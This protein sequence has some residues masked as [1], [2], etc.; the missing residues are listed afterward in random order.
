M[1]V[2]WLLHDQQVNRQTVYGSDLASSR[3]RCAYAL[4]GLEALGVDVDVAHMGAQD[5]NLAAYDVAVVG[6][7]FSEK[8]PLSV[9]RIS[10]YVP[11][12]LDC[13]DISYSVN[14]GAFIKASDYAAAVVVGSDFLRQ[15][16]YRKEDIS[17]TVITDCCRTEVTPYTSTTSTNLFWCGYR[18]NSELLDRSGYAKPHVRTVSNGRVINTD[19]RPFSLENLYE[20]FRWADVLLLPVGTNDYYQAKG[21]GRLL[22]AIAHGV[23]PVA[24]PHPAWNG[25]DGL[26]TFETLQE[27]VRWF[28]TNRD[29]EVAESLRIQ[30]AALEGLHSPLPIAREW[31]SVF[32]R[33]RE[34]VSA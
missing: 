10:A 31:M 1:R 8:L 29:S 13:C 25:F 9:K 24:Q 17:S 18:K 5:I 16:L 7:S 15:Y 26:R 21:L 6:K 27:G 33:V 34:G 20:G 19:Y 32:E 30:Q 2:L 4:E 3:Y 11:V 23:F 22:E 14:S 28:E 12:V